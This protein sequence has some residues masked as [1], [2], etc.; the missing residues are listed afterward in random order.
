ILSAV[1]HQAQKGNARL[2]VTYQTLEG[3]LEELEKA[4]E[5]G[6][7][8]ALR[9]RYRDLDILLLDDVQFLAGQPEAQEMLLGALDA[10]TASGSQVTGEEVA[11]MLGQT[12]AAGAAAAPAAAK[13][14]ADE[15]ASFMNEIS[16]TVATTVE[17]QEEAWRKTFRQAAEAAER[18]GFNAVRL[19]EL[20]E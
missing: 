7:R 12:S 14:A 17:E 15:F 19:R 1:A 18:E 2:R 8:D 11:K 3:Y 10:L 20:L 13:S 16:A 9:E 5:T 6:E 4:L